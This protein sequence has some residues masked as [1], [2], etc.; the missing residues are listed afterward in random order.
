MML[1]KFGWI[2][3]WDANGLLSLPPSAGNSDQS[4][5]VPLQIRAPVIATARGWWRDRQD[6]AGLKEW[7]VS[8]NCER[9]QTAAATGPT[10]VE[11]GAYATASIIAHC[12]SG[13]EVEYNI[14]SAMYEVGYG[15]A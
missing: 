15:C 7:M 3:L 13:S 5:M 12:I 6:E 10:M 8:G 9:Y 1:C 2:R 14:S 11:A 4:C